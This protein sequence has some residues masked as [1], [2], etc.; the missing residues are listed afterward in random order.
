MFLLAAAWLLAMG[1][2]FTR[3]P[4]VPEWGP[5]RTNERAADIAPIDVDS[6]I[7]FPEGGRDPFE[8]AARTSERKGGGGS[9]GDEDDNVDI[10]DDDEDSV[11][12]K[13]DGRTSEAGNKDGR[14][15]SPPTVPPRFVGTISVEDSGTYTVVADGDEYVA[16]GPRGGEA[17][18]YRLVKR[19]AAYLLL[20]DAAGR[21]IRVAVP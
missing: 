21:R 17:R 10:G 2:R 4:E 13:D 14:T 12:D 9:D 5:A 18:R 15:K 1:V 7:V 16:L 11:D 8:G 3:A 19:T 6:T 20:E